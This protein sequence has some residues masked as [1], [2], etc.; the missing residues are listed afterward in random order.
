MQK[1]HVDDDKDNVPMSGGGA[2]KGGKSSKAFDREPEAADGIERQVASVSGIMSTSDFDSLN[3][4]PNTQKVRTR[5]PRL[6]RGSS[7]S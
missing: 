3:L 5:Q 2:G 4:T 7:A 6:K 1:I